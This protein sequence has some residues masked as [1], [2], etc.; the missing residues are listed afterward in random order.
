MNMNGESRIVAPREAVYAALN[1]VEILQRA[2]PGCESIEKLSD[3]EMTA[4]VVARVGPV[5]A[6]FNGRVTFSDLDPPQSYTIAG[7]GKGGAAG[8][9]K[10][11]A[12]VELEPDGEATIL[13]YTVKAD[14]GGKLAQVG[15]RLIDG[16]AKKMADDFFARFAEEL[17]NGGDVPAT[18]AGVPTTT[19]KSESP[20]WTGH[21]GWW[22]LGGAIALIALYLLVGR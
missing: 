20:G 21:L 4:T 18:A 11:S 16:T 22:A 12:R 15:S 17:A 9:A 19:A 10:G 14:V 6:K 8:F 1:D 13:R 7:E 3:T 2:I 5:R